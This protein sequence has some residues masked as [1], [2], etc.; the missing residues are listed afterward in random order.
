MVGDL[1]WWFIWLAGLAGLAGSLFISSNPS[2]Q[3]LES[4]DY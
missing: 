3:Q 2:D 4:T 1:A